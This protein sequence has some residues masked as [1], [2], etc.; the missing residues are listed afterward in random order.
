M[1]TSQKLERN[2]TWSSIRRRIKGNI[3]ILENGCWKWLPT[4]NEGG[5]GRLWGDM[6]HRLSYSAYI[7]PI[8]K[9]LDID[10]LCRNRYCVNPKHLEPVTRRDN[11]LRGIGT[12]L[13]KR[14][15]LEKTHCPE[16]HELTMENIYIRPCDGVRICMTCKKIK[17]EKWQKENKIAKNAYKREWR[18]Q[19]K[20]KGVRK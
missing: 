14:K 18:K 4:L 11:L 7:G 15:A 9:G 19:W 10:H 20:L 5:Y 3:E 17:S 16:G 6:A 12:D 2:P 13:Q 1:N 8:G